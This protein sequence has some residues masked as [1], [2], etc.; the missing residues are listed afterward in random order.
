MYTHISNVSWTLKG[1]MS[2]WYSKY[3]RPRQVYHVR[4]IEYIGQVQIFEFGMYSSSIYNLG[5][6]GKSF[7]LCLI[8]KVAAEKLATT[9]L[10]P[11]TG[12]DSSNALISPIY[13]MCA[14]TGVCTLPTSEFYKS[15]TFPLKVVGVLAFGFF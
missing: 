12:L 5:T 3:V 11:Y 13:M 4:C 7:Q 2:F 14:R 10:H 1:K 9:T 8:V 15:R 6:R